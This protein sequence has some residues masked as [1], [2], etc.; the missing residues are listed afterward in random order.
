MSMAW[1]VTVTAVLFAICAVAAVI[2]IVSLLGTPPVVAYGSSTPGQP[3]N[4]TLQSVGSYGSPPHPTWVSYLVRSPQGQWVHTTVFQVPQHT[5]INFTIYNYDS[6]SPLRNQQIGQ[7]TGIY[8]NAATLNGKVFRVINSNAGN[9]VAHTFSIPS[10][11]VNVPLYANNGNA[12]LCA[13][14]PCTTKSPYQVIRFSI[15]SPGP[16]DY[17]WQCFVPCGLGFLFGNGG[18]MSTLGYMGGFMKVVA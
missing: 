16:G 11:G 1:K 12:N 14:A 8:G 10:L 3:V 7:V 13:A 9:M 15:T 2:L 18:P 4:V 17:R 5:R 6:G